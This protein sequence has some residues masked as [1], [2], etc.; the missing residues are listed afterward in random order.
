[1]EA[2]S[3]SWMVRCG[4]CGFARSIWEIGGI[5]WKAVGDQRTFLKCPQCGRRSWHRVTRQA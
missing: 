1:M 4:R 3:R 2:H 5:R